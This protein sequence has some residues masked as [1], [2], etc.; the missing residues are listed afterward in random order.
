MLEGVIVEVSEVANLSKTYF[1]CIYEDDQEPR[2]EYAQ[3]VNHVTLNRLI[4]P[5]YPISS[6][7]CC[8]AFVVEIAMCWLV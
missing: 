8:F 5:S 4:C 2:N 7:R 3:Q 1:K 6:E